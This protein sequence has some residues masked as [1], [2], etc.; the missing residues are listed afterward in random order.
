M[1]A[2]HSIS[3]GL[4]ELRRRVPLIVGLA[5]AALVVV[6]L[7]ILALGAIL[8]WQGDTWYYGIVGVAMIAAGIL[9]G[10][11]SVIGVWLYALVLLGTVIWA[12]ANV[13][14]DGW[15]LIPRI[16]APAVLGLL[17][18]LPGVVRG[19]GGRGNLGWLGEAVCVLLIAATFALGYRITDERHKVFATAADWN[20]S[21]PG[22]DEAGNDWRYYGRTA[23]GDRYVPFDQITPANVAQLQKVWEFRTGDMPRHGENANG[24]EFSFE[25]TPLKIGDTLYLCTPHRDVLALDATTG[26]QIWR[27]QPGGDLSHNVYQACRGVSY[28]DAS[29][30][31]IAGPSDADTPAARAVV[32]PPGAA[33][34]RIDTSTVPD[35]KLAQTVQPAG[36]GA[37][38]QQR[39]V[40]TDSDLPRL[41]E[42][43]AKTGH[44]CTDFGDGGYVD[45]RQGMGL[46]PPGFHFISS[47]PMVMDGRIMLSGWVYDNQSKG[48]PSGVIRAF[49]AVTGKLSWAWDVGRVPAT[50]P[51]GDG[52][53][54]TRGTPNGWGVFTADPKLN[55][56]YIP[57]GIATPDYF[58]GQRRPFDETYDTSLV[59][60]DAATG[61]ERWHFQAVHHDIWDF[62]LPVGPSLVDLPGGPNGGTIPALV[63]TNKQGQLFLLNRETGQPIATVEE[64]PV[65]Q[66]NTPGE[67]YSP[68][69]P[70]STG[71]PSFTPPPLKDNDVWGAT[72]IDQALCRIRFNNMNKGPLFTPI[73][74]TETLGNP[75]FDG[76][77]DWF[78]ATIDPVRHVLYANLTN[79]PF[80]MQLVPHDK[81]VKEGLIKDW[82]GWGHPFPQG[83]FDVNPQ[84][85]LPYA[86]II[87]PWLSII[88]APCVNAPW[89]HMEAIDLV[90]RKVL[91]TRPLGTTANMGPFGVRIPVGL[92]TGIFSMGGSIATRSGL[93]FIGG[94]TDQAFRAID[95]KT[96]DTLWETTLPAGGNATPI[97]YM[98]T[99]GRQYVVIDVG[100]HGGMRSRNGDYIIGFALPKSN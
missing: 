37:P 10:R 70:F 81:A 92:P 64:K 33:Q 13:G 30:G 39:I 67:H 58:G 7:V 52:E 99:D 86:A 97:S 55:L 24:R 42:L 29:A 35:T 36:D 71:M 91:W 48:E 78:G 61:Q 96:G 85:Y 49:D 88:Q 59:A 50:K 68:T 1:A 2:S 22:T 23:A 9:L 6:G 66:G 56:V 73:S 47:P 15:A 62:D 60:L 87:R 18:F 76:V 45:L 80:V 79:Q 3:E 32:A 21:A 77:M 83:A 53:T 11:L 25:A 95:A 69:Q 82:A 40:S 100:G 8:I 98:G 44:L 16:I 28:F 57:T 90:T 65:P 5:A 20:A 94:T 17:V 74:T 19:V 89:G 31:D 27:F 38:C 72:P 84:Y 26:K 41:F 54:F 43:D 4:H 46:I 63:Q 12:L 34:T 93:L 14:L 51:L 75:A